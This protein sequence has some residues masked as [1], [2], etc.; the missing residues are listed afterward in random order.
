[1]LKDR[2]KKTRLEKGLTQKQIAE[3]LGISYQNY[4]QWERGTRNPKENTV[5]MIADVLDVSAEYLTG[6]EYQID[7]S[8]YHPTEKDMEAIKNLINEYFKK[9]RYKIGK[10]IE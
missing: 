6:R 7:L 5:Q 9:R 4:Q 8:M 2:L 10:N 1:M 3:L